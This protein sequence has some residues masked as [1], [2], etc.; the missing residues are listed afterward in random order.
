[1]PNRHQ[2]YPRHFQRSRLR[3][4]CLGFSRDQGPRYF[5]HRPNVNGDGGDGVGDGDG[6]G[7]AGDV[8]S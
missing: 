7:G 8:M 2:R 4:H 1:M 5:S 3:Y 6:D